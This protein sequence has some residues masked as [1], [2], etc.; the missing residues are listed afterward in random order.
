MAR[1]FSAKGCCDLWQTAFGEIPFGVV[2]FG[3]FGTSCIFS[4]VSCQTKAEPINMIDNFANTLGY[5]WIYFNFF[6]SPKK[7]F[8]A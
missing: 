1:Y 4:V 7:H 6:R 8:P 5:L 3:T 2:K